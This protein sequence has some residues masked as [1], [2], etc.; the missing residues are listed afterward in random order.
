MGKALSHLLAV[1]SAWLPQCVQQGPAV[2]GEFISSTVQAKRGEN[3]WDGST[4]SSAV[5]GG[6]W[7]VAVRPRDAGM[8]LLVVFIL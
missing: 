4:A 2:P 3:K 8:S 6:P 5:I 7:H 1:S